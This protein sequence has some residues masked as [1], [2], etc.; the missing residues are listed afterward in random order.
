M[1]VVTVRLWAGRAR[2]QKAE[3][4]RR[5]TDAMVE[6]TGCERD[7]MRVLFEDYAKADWA[8]GGRLADEPERL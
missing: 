1:P 4:A 7:T 5:I 2:E 8:I 3:L 6:V